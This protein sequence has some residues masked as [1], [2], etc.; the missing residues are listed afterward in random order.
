MNLQK[1]ATIETIVAVFVMTITDKYGS[2]LITV[3]SSLKSCQN[4]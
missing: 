1:T 3:S 2:N 4:L